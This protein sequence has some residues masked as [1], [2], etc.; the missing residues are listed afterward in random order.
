M[1]GSEHKE[2]YR[3]GQETS[4]MIKHQNKERFEAEA[5]YTAKVIARTRDCLTRQVREAVL[6]RRCL[7]YQSSILKQMASAFSL[8]GTE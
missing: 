6:I 3:K 4:F 7:E 5:D 1:R 8:Q 2:K